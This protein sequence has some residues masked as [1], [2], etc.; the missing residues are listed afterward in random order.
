MIYFS[1]FPQKNLSFILRIIQKTLDN[2]GENIYTSRT[3]NPLPYLMK[4]MFMKYN[5]NLHQWTFIS[6]TG[7]KCGAQ[8][9]F[10]FLFI[11]V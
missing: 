7:S 2:V 9:S 8:P 5:T 10:L 4:F 1:D 3:T 11:I 6:I